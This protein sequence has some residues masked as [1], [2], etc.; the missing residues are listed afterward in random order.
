MDDDGEVLREAMLE[1]SATESSE[2][3]AVSKDG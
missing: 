1:R 3:T 2:D